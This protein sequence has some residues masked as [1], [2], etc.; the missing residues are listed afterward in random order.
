MAQF[1]I[2]LIDIIIADIISP[3]IMI[4]FVLATLLFFFGLIEYLAK[5]SSEEAR[6]KGRQHIIWGIFGLL[7]MASAGAIIQIMCDFFNVDCWL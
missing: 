4:L 5:G 6:T 3:L 1:S 2:P 7:I